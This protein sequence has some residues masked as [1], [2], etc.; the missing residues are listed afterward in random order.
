MSVVIKGE[1]TVI[2]SEREIKI[3]QMIANGT[4]AK[5]AAIEM[6]I[7]AR[8]MEGIIN[9]LRGEFDCNTLSHLVATF[10]RQKLID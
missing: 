10:L 6:D 1:N 9:K 2:I 5:Q 4:T 8:T 3:I 7:K